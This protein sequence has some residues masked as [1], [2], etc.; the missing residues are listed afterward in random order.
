MWV[1]QNQQK[2]FL[3]HF[4]SE[5]LQRHFDNVVPTDERITITFT[6]IA[7]CMQ[8]QRHSVK[9]QLLSNYKFH[10]LQNDDES[11]ETFVNTVKHEAKNWFPCNNANCIVPSIMI[12]D[13]IVIGTANKDI[14]PNALKNRW[15]LEAQIIN[16]QQTEA[17]TQSAK[18]IQADIT[19][20][21]QSIIN[22][23]KKPGVTERDLIKKTWTFLENHQN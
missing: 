6:T 12:R 9:N 19:L 5:K 18:Q 14:T 4:A 21:E 17:A 11:F 3:R 16:D 15:D 20:E 1:K 23:L 8:V 13:Q 7:E 2:V 10:K 22:W